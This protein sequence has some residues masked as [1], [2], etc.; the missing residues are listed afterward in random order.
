LNWER[1]K[2]H[3]RL[4]GWLNWGALGGWGLQRFG[5]SYKQPCFPSCYGVRGK[6]GLNGKVLGAAVVMD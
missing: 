4:F 3:R 2:G 6:T 1:E 5:G